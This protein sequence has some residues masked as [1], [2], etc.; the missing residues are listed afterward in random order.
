MAADGGP[1]TERSEAFRG[2]WSAL[3]TSFGVREESA[4]AAAMIAVCDKPRR[5]RNQE[6]TE[7]WTMEQGESVRAF[8]QNKGRG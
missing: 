4:L 6:T 2:G 7:G 3:L 1:K 5:P 8:F